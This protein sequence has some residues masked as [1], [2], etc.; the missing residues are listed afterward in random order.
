MPSQPLVF[1]HG[2]TSQ[3]LVEVAKGGVQGGSVE[4]T[5]IPDPA[6]QDGIPHARQVVEGLIA[7]QGDS[8][9]PHLLA[10][11]LRRVVAHGRSEAHEELPPPSLRPTRPE[12]VPEKIKLLMGMPSRPIVILAV[13]DPRLLGVHFQAAVLESTRDARQN[14]VRLLLRLAVRHHS[15]GVPLERNVRIRLTYPLVKRQMQKNVGQKG[16]NDASRTIDNPDRDGVPEQ[17]SNA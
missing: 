5:V 8:P 4:A 1:P 6:T 10:H 11:R 14:L 3:E 15:V 9:A 7:P 12:R 2:P 17:E 16:T 13:D